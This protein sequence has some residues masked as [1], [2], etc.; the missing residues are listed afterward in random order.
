MRLCWLLNVRDDA[1]SMV[2]LVEKSIGCNVSPTIP[3]LCRSDIIDI[4]FQEKEHDRKQFP[5]Y[6]G[7]ME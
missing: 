3:P 1:V 7:E 2:Q 6:E 5:I 4:V